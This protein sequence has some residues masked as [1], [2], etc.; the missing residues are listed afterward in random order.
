MLPASSEAIKMA[1]LEWLM[2]SLSSK[3]SRVMKIDMVNPIPPKNP[4]PIIFFHFRSLGKAQSPK[5]VPIKENNQIPN[6][7]PIAILSATTK[8][9]SM[10][11]KPLLYF[12]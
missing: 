1:I 3:A 5:P 7:F 8:V 12:I 6:G 9:R 11:W 2:T 4:A 10:S